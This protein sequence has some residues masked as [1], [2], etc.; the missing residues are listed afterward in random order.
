MT[1]QL[2]NAHQDSFPLSRYEDAIARI[3]QNPND[4][5]AQHQAVL[6]LARM[7]STDFALKEYERYCLDHERE[8]E[9]IIALKGRLFKDLY[10]KSKDVEAQKFALMSAYQYDLAYK[11]THGYYS[12]IN[13][14]TMFFLAEEPDAQFQQRAQKILKDLSGVEP[15]SE[16]DYYFIEAT[17]AE[18]YL[19]LEDEDRTKK[20]LRNAFSYDPLNY[21]AHAATLKQLGL[22]QIHKNL[23]TDW[24]SEFRPP[25]PVHFGGHLWYEN[26]AL[27]E[28]DLKISFSDII[29][30]HDFGFAYG[31]LAAGADILMAECFLAEGIPL[32]IMLPESLEVFCQQSVA[33]FGKSWVDRYEYCLNQAMSVTCLSTQKVSHY[34]PAIKF[35]TEVSMGQTILRARTFALSP[36]QCLFLDDSRPSSLSHDVKKIWEAAGLETII[37]SVQLKT[38]SR[39]KD[40]I[41]ALQIQWS[42][43]TV[44]NS[45][46]LFKTQRDGLFCEI[47]KISQDHPNKSIFID[48]NTSTADHDTKNLLDH[49]SSPTI[50]LSEYVAAHLT[51]YNPNLTG[52]VYAG[53]VHGDED[54]GS[55]HIY[56]LKL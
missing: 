53:V 7:G 4:R 17:R 31:A 24:L 56:S 29:Q 30:K 46:V 47:K 23:E 45:P 18:A 37:N 50:F 9:D 54:A 39:H 42:L 36:V 27:N 20:S 21:M 1:K 26:S 22:I 33:P 25:K 15:S 2:L 44:D 52:M 19:L 35:A 38:P 43:H 10:L 34:D 12:G 49:P 5:L 13:A 6:S 51:L 14:A 8:D 3:S 16:R 32:H 41:K 55:T 48:H 28:D 11:K 40:F